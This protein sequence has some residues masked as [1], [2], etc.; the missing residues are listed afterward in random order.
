MPAAPVART[1]SRTLSRNRAYIRTQLM[2][3]PEQPL[4][5]ETTDEI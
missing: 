3:E 2:D 4:P 5:A 1:I